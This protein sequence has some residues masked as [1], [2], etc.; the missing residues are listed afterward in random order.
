MLKH[1]MCQIE[2]HAVLMDYDGIIWSDCTC[3]SAFFWLPN[4][5][6]SSLSARQCEQIL[7]VKTLVLMNFLNVHLKLRILSFA[8]RPLHYRG[9]RLDMVAEFFLLDHCLLRKQCMGRKFLNWELQFPNFSTEILTASSEQYKQHICNKIY[10]YYLIPR[11]LEWFPET[12]YSKD[13]Q[14]KKSRNISLTPRY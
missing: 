3:L 10:S 11:L 6:T 4:L 12:L 7:Q 8:C 14:K 9:S 5:W 13:I 2:S 1:L